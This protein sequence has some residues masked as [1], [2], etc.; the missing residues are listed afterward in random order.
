M[1]QR[2]MTAPASATTNLEET[3]ASTPIFIPAMVTEQCALT[4][5]AIVMI[6]TLVILAKRQNIR[7]VEPIAVVMEIVVDIGKIC[8][9]NSVNV[10][11]MQDIADSNV[12]LEGGVV[13]CLLPTRIWRGGSYVNVVIKPL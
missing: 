8:L 5:P 1:E 2:N 11:V 13:H 6:A 4:A 9:T 3:T 7:A 12:K 10:I